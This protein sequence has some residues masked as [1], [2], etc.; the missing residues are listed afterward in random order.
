MRIFV[1]DAFTDRPFGGN[2]AAVVLLDRVVDAAWMQRL[3]AEMKHSETAFVRE[4]LAAC[5][6]DVRVNDPFKGVELVRAFADPAAGRHS[7]QIEVDRALYM[8]QKTLEKL[9]G[10]ARLQSDLAALVKAVAGYVRACV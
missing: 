1:V 7:L 8:D 9:P 6:Y 4:R 2:P 3:A 5:A 10:F